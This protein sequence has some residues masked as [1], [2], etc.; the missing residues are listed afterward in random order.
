[1]RVAGEGTGPALIASAA[2]S[3]VGFAIVAPA[4]MPLFASYSLLAALM[5][6]IAAG[7]A[8]LVLPGLLVLATAD[9]SGQGS[10]E[11]T[12]RPAA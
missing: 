10:P 9:A 11:A 3:A 5:I 1:V 6:V 7:A 4:P 12:R 8:G 2:S